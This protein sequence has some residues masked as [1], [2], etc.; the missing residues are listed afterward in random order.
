MRPVLLP[1]PVQNWWCPNCTE[2]AVTHIPR[3][4]PA[5]QFHPCRGLRGLTAPMLQEGVDAKVTAREWED[6]ENG[7]LVQ[8]DGEGRPISAVI[9][10]RADGSNDTAVLAPTARWSLD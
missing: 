8:R 9:T 6:Y 7:E 5:S 4:T 3:G 2:T 10:T 1:P